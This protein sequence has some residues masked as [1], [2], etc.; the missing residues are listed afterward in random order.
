MDIQIKNFYSI[1]NLNEKL[2]FFFIIINKN[3]M[4]IKVIKF[5]TIF[6]IIF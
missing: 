3:Y 6:N 5:K 4:Q 2:Y 1:K